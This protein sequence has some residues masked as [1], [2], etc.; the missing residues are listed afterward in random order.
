MAFA[1]YANEDVHWSGALNLFRSS[2]FAERGFCGTCGT[3][4]TYRW[5]AGPN[6]SLTIN[7]FDDPEAVRPELRYSP[8][9]EVSWGRT[10]G[11][12]PAK[13]LDVTGASGFVSYQRE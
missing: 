8:D 1:R 11:E 6:I 4:L 13:D 2:T 12:L 9:A 7:S 10:L 3:P 5:I